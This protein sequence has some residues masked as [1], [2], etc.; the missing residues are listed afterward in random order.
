MFTKTQNY[1]RREYCPNLRNNIIKTIINIKKNNCVKFKLL[2]T[3]TRIYNCF[4]DK[5][6]TKL[7]YATKTIFAK[8]IFSLY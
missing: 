5:Q 1:N 3:H 6:S 8:T 7:M 4:A 2:R